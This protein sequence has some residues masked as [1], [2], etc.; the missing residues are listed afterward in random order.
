M[1]FILKYFIYLFLRLFLFIT[2]Y[3]I[4][5]LSQKMRIFK[6]YYSFYIIIVPF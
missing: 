1:F 6:V 5:C 3:V 2:P 4:K